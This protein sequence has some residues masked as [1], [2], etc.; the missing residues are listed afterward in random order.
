MDTAGVQARA[1]DWKF[2]LD[3]GDGGRRPS[4]FRSLLLS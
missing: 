4:H 2:D 3:W 1:E